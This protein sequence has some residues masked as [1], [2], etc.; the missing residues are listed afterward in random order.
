MA[1]PR[2]PAALLPKL[3]P[4]LAA[5]KLLPPAETA[6]PLGSD[7]DRPTTCPHNPH[8]S[9]NPSGSRG[10]QLQVTADLGFFDGVEPS[11]SVTNLGCAV[12]ERADSTQERN[13]DAP[14]DEDDAITPE[15]VYGW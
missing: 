10:P 2:R 15:K 4:R 7:L 13:P 9:V 14:E 1:T 11:A 5:Q 3:A 12:A 8:M 6:C